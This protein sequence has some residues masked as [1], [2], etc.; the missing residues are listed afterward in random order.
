MRIV[1]LGAGGFIGS[2]VVEHLIARAE[3]EVV[4][5]DCT[6]EKLAGVEGPNFTFHEADIRRAPEL[7]EALVREA[8]VVVDLIAHANPSMYVASPLEVFDLNFLQN[9]EIARLCMRYGVRLIQYSSAEVYGKQTAGE[10][11]SEDDTDSVF[12]PVHKQRWIYAAGKMLLER[13]LYAHGVA[14]DLDYTIVRPFN[15]LGSRID[16]LVPAGAVG[17]PRVFPHFMSALLTGGPLRLVDGGNVHRAFLHIADASRAFQTVL[18][19]HDATRNGIY[20][21]GNPANNVTVRAFADLMRELYEELTGEAPASPL[22][23][24]SGEAFYGAGYEDGNRLPPDISKM[25]ALGWAPEHDLRT[26]V[27]DAMAYYIRQAG[28]PTLPWTASRMAPA[29]AG[30]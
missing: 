3:H 14:G 25:R 13:V 23:E 4:G 2:H 27:R 5:L 21:V 19:R 7:V 8:D 10:Q 9:L 22:E 18:D 30:D 16:Y 28:V 1:I 12:G 29:V 20:N 11:Y 6:G 15:F 26:T 17:G 24:M